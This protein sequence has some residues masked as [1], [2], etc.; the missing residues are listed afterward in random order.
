MGSSC[1]AEAPS[2]SQCH[3][4]ERGTGGERV[5]EK[6]AKW[7]SHVVDTSESTQESNGA[8]SRMG[9]KA[10]SASLAPADPRVPAASWGFPANADQGFP[11]GNCS[12]LPVESLMSSKENTHNMALSSAGP[13]IM[14]STPLPGCGSSPSL[15]EHN[16]LQIPIITVKFGSSCLVRHKMTRE[17]ARAVAGTGSAIA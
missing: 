1:L 14:S 2:S 12:Q 8:M 5:G 11:P 16:S 10:F 7:H 4:R 13:L 17:D 6:A 15:S 9:G 3:S